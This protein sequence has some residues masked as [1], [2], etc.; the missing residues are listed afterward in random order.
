MK[1][2]DRLKTIADSRNITL[3]QLA[4]AGVLHQG[5]D[6]V[7]IPGTRTSRYLMENIESVNVPLDHQEIKQIEAIF[8]PGAVKGERYTVEGMKGVNA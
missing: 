7:P 4:L 1:L 2:V 5:E 8:Y 3:S 6:I